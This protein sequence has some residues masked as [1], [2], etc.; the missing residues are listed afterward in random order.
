[1]SSLLPNVDDLIKAL[2]ETEPN[3]DARALAV[4][5]ASAQSEEELDRVL[6]TTVEGWLV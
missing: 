5:A 1:M 4:A 2:P 6:S 3:A